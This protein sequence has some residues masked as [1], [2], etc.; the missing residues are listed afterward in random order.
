MEFRPILSYRL[1]TG[2][3][4]GRFAGTVEAPVLSAGAEV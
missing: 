4:Y 3:R 2:A 1:V